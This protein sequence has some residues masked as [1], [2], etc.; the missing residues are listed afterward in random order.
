MPK[1]KQKE[2]KKKEALAMTMKRRGMMKRLRR[3]RRGQSMVSYAIVTAAML[4]GLT[5]MG[6]VIFPQMINAMNSFT[7]SLYFCIN[8][9]FP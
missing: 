9:P 2:E 3:G 5:T 8:L 4:G 6:M 7:A 1:T